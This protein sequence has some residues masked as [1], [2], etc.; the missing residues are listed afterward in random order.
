MR[1]LLLT[2]RAKSALG[3]AV[4]FLLY[5]VAHHIL[6]AHWGES[7]TPIHLDSIIFAS[8]FCMCLAAIEI[9]RANKGVELPSSPGP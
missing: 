3:F 9:F 4:G 7:Y 1:S 6:E 8:G 2:K 5:P